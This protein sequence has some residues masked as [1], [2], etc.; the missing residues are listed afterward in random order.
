MNSSSPFTSSLILLY[1]HFKIFR[2]KNTSF[3]NTS[4]SGL[5]KKKTVFFP[6]TKSKSHSTLTTQP[7][8]LP[9]IL[10]IQI[11]NIICFKKYLVSYTNITQHF[12]PTK[13]LVDRFIN[14]STHLL[15]CGPFLTR[16]TIMRKLTSV[17]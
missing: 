10:S 9:S 4:F 17:T 13:Y 3:I 6:S 1:I 12:S 2:K 5:L 8:Y 11:T 14:R 15:P 16:S 7:L